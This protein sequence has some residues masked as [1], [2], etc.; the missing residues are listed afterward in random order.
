MSDEI[1]DDPA[2]TAFLNET[3]RD[4]RVGKHDVLVTEVRHETWEKSGEPRIKILGV[5]QTANNAK[6]D[7]T[8]SPPPPPEVIKAEGATWESGKKK[9]IASSITMQK[10]LMKWY[11]KK[12]DQL[13]AGDVLRVQTAKTK[14]DKDGKGGFIRIV[15]VLD[16]AAPVDQPKT[17]AK[18]DDTPF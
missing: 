7:L 3:N 4:D 9:A 10:N 17:A 14:I 11:S 6:C 5:L 15:A 2:Y 16:P 12:A 13:Q 8:L 1:L 18:K